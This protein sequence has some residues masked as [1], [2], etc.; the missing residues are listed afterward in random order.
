MQNQTNYEKLE[1]AARARGR[2]GASVKYALLGFWGVVVLFPFYWMILTSLKSYAAYNGERVPLLYTLAP[3][4]K[5]YADAFTAVP[6]F[7]YIL[8]T[9]IFTVVTVALM[10]VISVLAAFAF[11]RLKFRGKDLVIHR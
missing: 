1:R 9:V 2:I 3:T 7:D 6:L 4:L 8:N 10:L 5:N 11:A